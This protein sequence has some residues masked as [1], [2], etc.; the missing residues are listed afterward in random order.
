MNAFAGS[1]SD[2]SVVIGE[3]KYDAPETLG[4]KESAAIAFV[5]PHDIRVTREPGGPAMLKARVKHSNPIGP[6]AHV[7][8]SNALDN[9]GL[10]TVQLGKEQFRELNPQP[11]EELF[12]E[13]RNVKVFPEDFSSEHDDIIW[14]IIV[15]VLVLE[16]RLFSR[17][18]TTTRTRRSSGLTKTVAAPESRLDDSARFWT[19]AALCRFRTAPDL[20]KRQRAAAVQDA[21]AQFAC[22]RILQWLQNF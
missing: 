13:L 2:G 20:Q 7:S 6:F 18:T 12:V 14:G 11:G 17:T 8:I 5:R 21:G 16:F 19:A 4:E 1:V 9:G 3:T 15:L 10:F 22:S